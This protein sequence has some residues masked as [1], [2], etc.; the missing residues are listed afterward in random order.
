MRFDI[1]PACVDD[2]P[3]ILAILNQEILTGNANWNE[4]PKSLP[5]FQQWFTQ[6]QAQNFPLLVAVCAGTATIA[7]YADY[8]LF[9]QIQGYRHTVEHSVFVHPDYY[10]QGLGKRLM[11]ALIEIAQSQDIHVMVA[12]IDHS[13]IASI[14]LHQQLGFQQ[15]GYMPQ[16]GKKFGQWRDLV[17]MQLNFE[18]DHSGQ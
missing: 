12:A 10:R 15:T 14:E 9:R 7:A 6:L 8:D 16:I 18:S 13:N 11:Q 1:R 3:Q 4:D 5:Q 17:L 2:L